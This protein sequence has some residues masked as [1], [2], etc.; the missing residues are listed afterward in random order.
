[1][2]GKLK[3]A[4]YGNMF[5]WTL[6]YEKLAI[7]PHEWR[8]FMNPY[9]V[10]ILNKM[11]DGKQENNQIVIDDLYI[12]SKNLNAW[13][14]V[15]YKPLNVAGS[16]LN[17]KASV[18]VKDNFMRTESYR[19]S[20]T[21][22]DICNV[23]D[24]T[25][26][27]N[28]SCNHVS[29][30]S[31]NIF[32]QKDMKKC[33]VW[34][35]MRGMFTYWYKVLASYVA[36]E[37]ENSHNFLIFDNSKI[38]STLVITS[39][40]L[41]LKNE[42]TILEWQ[43]KLTVVTQELGKQILASKSHR[44]ALLI[45]GN[46][47][48][49]AGKGGVLFNNTTIGDAKVQGGN[50]IV[51]HQITHDKTAKDTKMGTEEEI[52]N[53]TGTNEGDHSVIIGD[54]TL[55]KSLFSLFLCETFI[56]PRKSL[57]LAGLNYNKFDQ[58][59][60]QFPQKLA[61]LIR[62]NPGHRPTK[63]M[64]IHTIQCGDSLPSLCGCTDS[65]CYSVDTVVTLHYTELTK[66]LPKTF[67]VNNG[68][69]T[70]ATSEIKQ[71]FRSPTNGARKSFNKIAKAGFDP[72]NVTGNIFLRAAPKPKQYSTKYICK[73]VFLGQGVLIKQALASD[74]INIL[75]IDRESGTAY[76]LPEKVIFL[77]LPRICT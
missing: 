76:V 62:S 42:T 50:E 37:K 34:H 60:K 19:W 38:T 65:E 6:F 2:Y 25:S 56:V 53:A 1:M 16:A 10:Y 21:D 11:T 47:S 74:I 33:A 70:N 44:K 29:I 41:I 77:L 35:K 48:K 69:S 4:I 23:T 14:V 46:T 26:I 67:F 15:V 49:G 54:P 32:W 36:E 27:N 5:G 75:Y 7:Q 24:R 13:L 40:R 59:I 71:F 17:S 61:L 63:L 22:D 55:D 51:A 52:N 45:S 72:N 9:N 8:Y 20:S 66:Q 28:G 12:S 30:T 31:I 43:K 58:A 39:V 68:S 73:L 18:Q 64:V 3:K 57:S